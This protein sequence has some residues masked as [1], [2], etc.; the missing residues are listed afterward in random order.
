M[1]AL[2]GYIYVCVWLGLRGT[3]LLMPDE[4][5]KWN[6]FQQNDKLVSRET[7]SPITWGGGGRRGG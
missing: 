7:I 5:C 6:T 4:L 3:F 1:T 2:Y